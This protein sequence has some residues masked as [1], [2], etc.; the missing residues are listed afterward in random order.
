MSS[1]PLDF[2]AAF[3][4]FRRQIL[5]RFE[6]N[7]RSGVLVPEFVIKAQ[8]SGARIFAGE[9]EH[10]PRLGGEAAWE[11]RPWWLP[12]TLPNTRIVL[13]NL[14]DLARLRRE[15]QTYRLSLRAGPVA[16]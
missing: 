8:L 3:K 2:D 14:A 1:P 10:R 5:D 9:T 12:V 6:L 4:V 15:I 7:C 16:D 13:Q 11:V